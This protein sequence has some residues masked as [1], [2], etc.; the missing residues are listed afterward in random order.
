MCVT[1]ACILEY[2][3]L[4]FLLVCPA[5]LQSENETYCGAEVAL[6]SSNTTSN[7]ANATAPIAGAQYASK[8]SGD[9]FTVNIPL[10]AWFCDKGS[11]GSLAA[12]DRVDFQNVNIRDAE[13]CLD[14]IRLV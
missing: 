10:S 7:A 13:V 9:W 1:L 3:T 2:K 4:Y 11:T 14:N 5:C 6:T 8:G 12:V